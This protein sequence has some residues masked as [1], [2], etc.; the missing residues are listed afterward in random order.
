MTADQLSVNFVGT[1]APSRQLL[2][3][4]GNTTPGQNVQA[5]VELVAQ[6]DENSVGFSL[7]YDPAVLSSPSVTLNPDAAAANLLF[8][9]SQTGKLGVLLSLPAGQAL[10]VGTRTL[11]TVTFATGATNLY[12]S[13]LTFGDIPIAKEIANFNADPLP[14]TY[15]DG[16]VTFAQG[17]EGDVAPRPTG[18]NNGTVTVADVTQIGRFVAGLDTLNASYNEF[19]RADCAP[20]ITLGNGL[21]TVA[22]YTQAGRYAA[23]LDIVS[24]SGGASSANF[25]AVPHSQGPDRP[26]AGSTTVRVVSNSASPGQQVTISIETDAQGTE[27]GFGFTLNYDSSKLSNPLISKGTD[28]QSATLIPNLNQTGRVGVVLAMPFGQSIVA[29]TKQL[30]TV[31]FDVSANAAGGALPL[32]LG[33]APVQREVS[34][35]DANVLSSIFTDGTLTILGP[36]AAGVSV[37]GVV[38]TSDGRPVSGAELRIA[39]SS[40]VVKTALSNPFGYFKFTDVPAGDNYV[41]S[42]TSKR[43]NFRSQLIAITAAVTDLVVVGQPKQ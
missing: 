19:Q 42:A 10:P 17:Y 16:A 20:R 4:G 32:T 26:D 13:P 33:D 6:G 41:V 23:G 37:S 7:N 1:P 31:R 22:D 14:T 8:N 38:L 35:V 30:V 28:T 21:I 12:N 24:P 34:D 39:D 25:A 3:I 5:T 27:N 2:V 40:G 18:N 29:G 9:S 11:V 36:T 43:F 15:S